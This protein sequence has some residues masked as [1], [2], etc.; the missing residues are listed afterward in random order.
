VVEEGVEESG[1]G[2]LVDEVGGGSTRK[3]LVQPT[4]NLNVCSLSQKGG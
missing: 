4:V 1:R 2:A 3:N